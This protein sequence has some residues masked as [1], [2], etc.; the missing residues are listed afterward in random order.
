[1][2]PGKSDKASHSYGGQSKRN[3][4]MFMSAGTAYVYFIYGMYFCFN[5]SSQEE[6]GCVLVRAL[7]PLR[8]LD[9]MRRNR[10]SGLKKE[11][12]KD[13]RDFELCNGPS[14]LCGAFGINKGNTNEM[15]MTSDDASVWIENDD[16]AES[17]KVFSVFRSTRIGI[18]GRGPE[19]AN[20]PYRFYVRENIH[21]SV[22]DK[23]DDQSPKK[24]RKRN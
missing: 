24:K 23:E 7:E 14:R 9:Q 5:V 3:G 22:F 21:V 6:G 8:G 13:L 16:D 20:L 19:Y 12:K 2:Y 1:M 17:D 18:E 11:R 10:D 15:D 4:A